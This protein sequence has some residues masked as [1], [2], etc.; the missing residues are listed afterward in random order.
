MITSFRIEIPQA[1][2]DDLAHR[3][4]Q[5]RWPD[6]LSGTDWQYGANPAYMKELTTYWRKQ[7]DWRAQEK[8]MNSYKHFRMNIDGFNVHFIH[9]R[10]R[11]PNPIPLMM[12][13]GWPG[14]FWEM[15]RILP[16]SLD[17]EKH[18]GDPND[19]FDVILPSLPGYGFSDRP[20]QPG[21][22]GPESRICL[23]N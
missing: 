22:N 15:H 3:L 17:P 16:M 21:M 11:G 1:K 20:S 8:K 2:L 6:S 7:F 13:H 14:T 23:Q 5:T 9:E 18:G 19:S 12:I 4:D 10:G